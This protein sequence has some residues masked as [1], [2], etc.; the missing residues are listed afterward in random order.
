[1]VV[2]VVLVVSRGTRSIFLPFVGIGS[3]V[4]CG[5]LGVGCGLL[6]VGCGL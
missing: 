5:L 1:M 6:G 3:V 2:V 4:G